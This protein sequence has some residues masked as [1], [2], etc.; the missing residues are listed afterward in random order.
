MIQ[1][2]TKFFFQNQML[3]RSKCSSPE[4][5]NEDLGICF[6]DILFYEHRWK[7]IPTIMS[8]LLFLSFPSM[9]CDFSELKI[10]NILSFLL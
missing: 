9:A 6:D 4:L 3:F 8:T 2:S 5:L 1:S 10:E 7:H